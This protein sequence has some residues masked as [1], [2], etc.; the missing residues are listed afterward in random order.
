MMS[1]EARLASAAACVETLESRRLLSASVTSHLAPTLVAAPAVH[2][3]PTIPNIAGLTYEGTFRRHGTVF[4]M[5][6]A[7]RSESAA[8]S[9]F[10]NIIG[11]FSTGA[12]KATRAV[13]LTGSG[14][15]ATVTIAGKLSANLHT[16]TGKLSV[17]NNALKYS[18]AFRITRTA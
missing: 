8:G 17:K 2:A 18:V 3:K 1:N 10:A 13:T 9:L 12:V 11:F 7:F 4:P 14:D 16:F 15:G 5:G 6:V